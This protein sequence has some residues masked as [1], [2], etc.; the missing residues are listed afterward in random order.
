MLLLDLLL[1]TEPL[2]DL[3]EDPELRLFFFLDFYSRSL[4]WG[5]TLD[6]FSVF[7][8]NASEF[9]GYGFFTKIIFSFSVFFASYSVA[10]FAACCFVSD[11]GD[12]D[13]PPRS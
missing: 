7:S 11:P 13:D 4:R 3:L 5:F 9:F 10:S 1:E 8:A 12:K 2:D 6:Y